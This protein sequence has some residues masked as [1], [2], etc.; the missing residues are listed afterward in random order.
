MLLICHWQLR[1]TLS[2]KSDVSVSGKQAASRGAD[3]YFLCNTIEFRIVVTMSVT[4]SFALFFFRLSVH[5]TSTLHSKAAKASVPLRRQEER[6]SS[7]QPT[8]AVASPRSS[9]FFLTMRPSELIPDVEVEDWIVEGL[10]SNSCLF[11]ICCWMLF[12]W[13]TNCY[14]LPVFGELHM[15]PY[16]AILFFDNILNEKNDEMFSIFSQLT[17]SSI[18][19]QTVFVK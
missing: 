1:S 18:R 4:D 11:E 2:S 9:Q 14:D 19:D 16:K 7:Q 12:K 5:V 15:Q 17:K 13:W 10:W 6:S 3:S 8:A